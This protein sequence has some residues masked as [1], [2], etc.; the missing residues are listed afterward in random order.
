MHTPA[1]L[2]LL[3]LAL[4]L[5]S[6]IGAQ[7][8]ERTIPDSLR[9]A[10]GQR[11]RYFASASGTWRSGVISRISPDSLW[12]SADVVRAQSEPGTSA[13]ALADLPALDV[14]RGDYGSQ[15]RHVLI[16]AGVGLVVGALAGV[17]A[18]PGCSS[19]SEFGCS[20]ETGFSAA[21]GGLLGLALGTIVGGVW[22]S[23][24]RWQRVLPHPRAP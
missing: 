17:I 12:L 14:A 15:G 9:I 2:K 5:P 20:L 3:L 22:P 1:L 4:V 24:P 11:V 19:R 23:G 16:G 7:Q 13:V 18:T 8:A 21:R 6:S 10:P